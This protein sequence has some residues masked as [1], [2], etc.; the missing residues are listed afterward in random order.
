MKRLKAVG[1]VLGVFFVWWPL[2]LLWRA[3]KWILGTK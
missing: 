3:C 2:F 1:I